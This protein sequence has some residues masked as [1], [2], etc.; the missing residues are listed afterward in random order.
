MGPLR[1]VINAPE[2]YDECLTRHGHWD[3]IKELT[4]K[5]QDL[6]IGCS[7]DVSGSPIYDAWGQ[8]HAAAP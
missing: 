5:A 4:R 1:H 6:G 8:I 7:E 3:R 2:D